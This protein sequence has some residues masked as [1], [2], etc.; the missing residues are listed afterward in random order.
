MADYTKKQPRSGKHGATPYG[1]QVSYA[2]DFATNASGVPLNSDATA[3]L[4]A[5]DTIRLG[6]IPAGTK[7]LDSIHILSDAFTATATCKLGFAYVDG[8]DSTAVPQDADYF[9]AALDLNT[10]AITRKSNA[11]AR[12]VTLPK[13]AYLVLDL[14]VATLAAAGVLDIVVLGEMVGAA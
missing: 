12:P 11:G 10:V 5:S 14:D 13:D 3:A 9:A 1:N 8:V 4:T 6:V 7:L 2:F